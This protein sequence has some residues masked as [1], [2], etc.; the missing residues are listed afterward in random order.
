MTQAWH[1]SQVI[2][3]LYVAIVFPLDQGFGFAV[4]CIQQTRN[5]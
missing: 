4:V 2:A 1:T 3:L 5:S